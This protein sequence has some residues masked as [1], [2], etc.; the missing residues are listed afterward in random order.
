MK[1]RINIFAVTTYCTPAWHSE[2]SGDRGGGEEVT[3]YFGVDPDD[4]SIWRAE[5]GE[6]RWWPV[7]LPDADKRGDKA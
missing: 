2:H 1:K 5:D 6:T 4:G 7:N 3:T